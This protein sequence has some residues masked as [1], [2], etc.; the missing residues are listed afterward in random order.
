[1]KNQK[2][3]L[4]RFAQQ[5]AKKYGIEFNLK[6]CDIKIPKTC[7]LLGIFIDTNKHGHT[8]N[9]PFIERIDTT[10]GYIPGNVW[11]IS[12]RA[13]DIKRDLTLYDL[14]QFLENLEIAMIEYK[15]HE[16]RKDEE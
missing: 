1:M 6:E 16:S 15:I 2:D 10:R 8:D 14:K 11:I 5:Q 7:P 9:S 12:H 13:H 3:N 4:L